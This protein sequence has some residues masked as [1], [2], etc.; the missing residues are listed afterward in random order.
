MF[1]VG[2]FL[3]AMFVAWCEFIFYCMCFHQDYISIMGDNVFQVG[4]CMT[5]NLP[6]AIHY[7]YHDHAYT[8][9]M[10]LLKVI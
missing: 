2:C 5:S 6:H 4:V 10:T 9:I 8:H 1:V 7:D 3:Y